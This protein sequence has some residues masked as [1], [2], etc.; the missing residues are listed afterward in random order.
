M[1]VSSDLHLL[2]GV[3]AMNALPEDERAEFEEHLADCDSC[4]QEVAELQATSVGL[5][6]ATELAPPSHLRSQVL[7]KLATTP[8]SPLE[9]TATVTVLASRSPK[10]WLMRASILTTAAAVLGAVVLGV[11]GVQDWNELDA[12]RQSAAGYSQVSDL[13]N[14]PD[15]KLVSDSASAGGKG[16]VVV[17]PSRGKAVFLSSGLPQ[18]PSDRTYQ[19]WMVG[20]DG[21]RS[22]GLL[23][24]EPVVAEGL[25]DAQ[26]LA[27]TI[28]PS[29]GSSSPTLPL[30]LTVSLV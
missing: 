15:A 19:L 10:K 21:P 26:K 16:T 20:P 11:Q 7:A 23:R 24:D 17:S 25:A 1:S 27:L 28:E 30:V 8:Q 3:Y 22:A 13:L 29:G 18:L 4:A 2:T 9:T 12:L 14:A 6:L 5:N